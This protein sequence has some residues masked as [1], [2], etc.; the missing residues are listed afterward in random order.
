M[1]DFGLSKQAESGPNNT[2]ENIST[3]TW[4]PFSK[5]K[6]DM[7][8]QQG[9]VL[10]TNS[11]VGSVHYLAP[12]VISG[13]SY[14]VMADWWAF[15]VLLYDMYYGYPP[16]KGRT[17]KQIITRI[18]KC[19]YTFP[20]GKTIS[21]N[22]KSLIKGLLKID[23]NKRI[24]KKHGAA[25]I[26]RHPFFEDTHWGLLRNR[27]PPIIPN[28]KSPCDTTHFEIYADDEDSVD[29]NFFSELPEDPYAITQEDQI[30]FSDF[31][32]TRKDYGELLFERKNKIKQSKKQS[33][34]QKKKVTKDANSTD[35]SKYAV[36]VVVRSKSKS[37]SPSKR[38]KT[39]SG[40]DKSSSTTTPRVTSSKKAKS[41]PIRKQSATHKEDDEIR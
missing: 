29:F 6:T 31:H 33:K 14:D 10:R 23:P 30:K 39:L 26:K 3:K 11:L 8:L 36:S 34:K 15:G 35:E 18:S 38:K 19:E 28:V 2:I 9:E 25:D 22:L 13:E 20:T 41:K 32:F 7:E 4:N 1:A 16:F 21:P 5:K 24:C 37:K 12:E 27:T 17:N 40:E